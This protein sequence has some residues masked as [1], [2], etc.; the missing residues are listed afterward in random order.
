[1]EHRIDLATVNG[2]VFVNNASLG[3]YAKIVQ[4]PE[5]R[6]AKRQTAA[7]MLPELLGPDAAPL[8]LRFAGPDGTEHPTAH[9]ILVSNDPYQLDRLAGLGTRERL[10]LGVLGVVAVRISDAGD[11]R[12][13][14]TLEAAG[15]IRRFPGWLEWATPRF[16]VD[17]AGPVEI[18]VD[19]EA[20]TMDPPLV[21]QT[22]PRVLRVR[23]PRH[24]IGLSPA[25]RAVHVA[26]R[27][28]IVELSR[29][30]AG[31]PV[32]GR[33]HDEHPASVGIS[34]KAS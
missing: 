34:A 2:R 26:S 14:L 30:V 20:L 1:M 5:Y 25:A 11:A 24:A 9:M 13:F 32:T 23:L 33:D 18:G 15:Q 10:D 7:A 21:F 27:S 31:Y 3:L 28:T 12:R 22:M 8:D 6:D 29:V 19:G 17:S 16:I 4:S